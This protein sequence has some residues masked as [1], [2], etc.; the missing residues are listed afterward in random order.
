M[1]VGMFR[2][3]YS[4]FVGDI[5][6]EVDDYMLYSVFSKKYGS[7]KAAK[8]KVFYSQRIYFFYSQ[9]TYLFSLAEWKCFMIPFLAMRYLIT[10]R[11]ELS[12]IVTIF[13]AIT[14]MEAMV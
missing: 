7:C 11:A 9:H 13:I 5:T 6:D 10:E 3:E 4:V 1:I 14:S 2:P 8:S 12:Q